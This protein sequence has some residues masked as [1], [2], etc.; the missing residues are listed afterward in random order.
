MEKVSTFKEFVTASGTFIA[1]FNDFVKR[2]NLKGNSLPDHIC[3]KCST[4]EYY[5]RL[6]KLFDFES[7]FMYQSIISSRRITY[8][9]FKIPLETDLGPIWYLELSDQKPDGSQ[10]DGFDHIEIYSTDLSY[11]DFVK[12]FE[13]EGENIM[14]V[15]RQHHTTYDIQLSSGFGIKLTSEQLIEK[16][17]REEMK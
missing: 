4:T 15:A 5:E 6:K 14:K 17:K 10:V 7:Q 8:I 3:F 11:D 1:E 13:I 16:I 9:K 12:K 2:H